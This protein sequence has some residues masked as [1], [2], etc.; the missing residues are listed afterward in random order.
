MYT[1]NMRQKAFTADRIAF[2]AKETLPV[3]CFTQNFAQIIRYGHWLEEV[4][5]RSTRVSFRINAERCFRRG[6]DDTNYLTE[7]LL[8]VSGLPTYLEHS[9]VN[10]SVV[11]RYALPQHVRPF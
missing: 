2:C 5:V 10:S 8:H 7:H 6:A 3:S 11:R 1:E 4:N 9:P